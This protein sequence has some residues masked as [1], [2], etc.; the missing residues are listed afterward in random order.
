MSAKRRQGAPPLPWPGW[1]TPEPIGPR[2]EDPDVADQEFAFQLAEAAQRLKARRRQLAADGLPDLTLAAVVHCIGTDCRGATLAEIR[3][4]DRGHLFIAELV[5]AHDQPPWPPEPHVLA[6]N[7]NLPPDQSVWL[8]DTAMHIWARKG[9]VLAPPGTPPPAPQHRT[10]LNALIV[11]D[12][13]DV[14]SP[15]HPPLRVKCRR[16]GEARLDRDKVRRVLAATPSGKRPA[17][18]PL[19][20]VSGSMPHS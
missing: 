4:T 9:W 3:R 7:V 19:P 5:Y 20:Q 11:R 16:H 13:L 12:L 1:P 8:P 10:Q 14:D 6:V 2:L 17:R 18:I 15:H